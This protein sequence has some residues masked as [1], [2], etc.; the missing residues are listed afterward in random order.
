MPGTPCWPSSS[1]VGRRR[2][3]ALHEALGQAGALLGPLLAAAMIAV[4]GFRLGFAALAVPGALALL[5]LA[6]L[7]RTVPTPAAYEPAHAGSGA[8]GAERRG[9]P[10]A[11]QRGL[12]GIDRVAGD[13]DGPRVAGS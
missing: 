6:W 5:T 8:V 9:V 1:P 2:A 10:D 4:S 13:L 7:R 3:F 11:R 12:G